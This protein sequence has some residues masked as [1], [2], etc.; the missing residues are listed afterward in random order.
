MR[1]DRTA[2]SSIA[3]FRRTL[4]RGFCAAFLF[5]TLTACDD[6]STRGVALQKRNTHEGPSPLT[7]SHYPRGRWRLAPRTQLSQ[8]ILW[9]SH[10]L[11]RYKQAYGVG[12]RQA[13]FGP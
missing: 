6:S 9:V 8:T 2:L 7:R 11:I 12:L 5:F 4:E 1:G 10:I 3:S 13:P